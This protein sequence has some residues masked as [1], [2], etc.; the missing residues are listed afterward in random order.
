[1]KIEGNGGEKEGKIVF[2]VRAFVCLYC[3]HCLFCV[4]MCL[5]LSEIRQSLV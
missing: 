2:I 3:L 4:Y 5:C 1:M